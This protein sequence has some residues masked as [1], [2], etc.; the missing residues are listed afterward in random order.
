MLKNAPIK[1]LAL[2]ALAAL[3]TA[4]AG[5]RYHADP[6]QDVG[7]HQMPEVALMVSNDTRPGFQKAMEKWLDR[8][9]YPYYVEAPGA[10]RPYNKLAL[11]HDGRWSWSLA[12]FMAEASIEAY[13]QGRPV[14]RVDYEAKNN[15]R[16]KK[17]G[18]AETRIQYM[19][20]A[21]FAKKSHGEAN[22]AIR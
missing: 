14:G 20:D 2:V 3:T 9:G 21:L 1:T 6:L 11:E 13:Y 10:E 22:R 7:K 12:T 4:C 18:H 19:M 17:F 15:F 8:N 5:P 16:L